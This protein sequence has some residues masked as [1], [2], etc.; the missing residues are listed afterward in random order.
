M[1][2]LSFVS[3]SWLLQETIYCPSKVPALR[4]SIRY[5]QVQ[6]GLAHSGFC[7][8]NN[9][10]SNTNG[11]LINGNSAQDNDKSVLLLLVASYGKC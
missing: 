4:L 7:T 8:Y 3:Q 5:L 2:K 6:S 10:F 11:I 1:V 9:I